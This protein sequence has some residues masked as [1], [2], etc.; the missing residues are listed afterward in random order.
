MARGRYTYAD[1]PGCLTLIVQN[2]IIGASIFGPFLLFGLGSVGVVLAI[3]L[4]AG[5]IYWLVKS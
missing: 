3:A 4:W 1:Q 5:F 2:L